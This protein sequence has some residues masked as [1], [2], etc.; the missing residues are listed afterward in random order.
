[1]SDFLAAMAESSRARVQTARREQAESTL[2]ARAHNVAVPPALVLS[3]AGF[4]L[5]AEVKLRSPAAGALAEDGRADVPA[6]AATYATAGAVAVSVLTEP[7]RFDGTLEHLRS[8]AAA[9]APLGVP[10]MRK[11]F[12]VD[13][14]Q[15]AEARLAGAAGVLVVLRMLE[16]E[17]LDL[18]LDRCAELRLFALLEAF[19]EADLGRASELV[20]A[21]SDQRLLVG[22]NCRDLATLQVMPQRLMELA[23]R[24]P[25][26]APCVAESGVATAGDAARV[27]AAGYDL[28]LVGS[29]L[30]TSADPAKLITD[31]LASGRCG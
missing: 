7:S 17:A 13:A 27:A 4:D 15:V 10:T 9:L 2:L 5:M 11:D 16:H 20:A 6:R 3:E 12:I 24:L 1:M 30:M 14:Y 31:M 19:D 8:A 21:R 25:R 23:D 28:A 29:A 22:V 18:I 26:R